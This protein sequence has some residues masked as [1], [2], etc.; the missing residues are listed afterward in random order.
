MFETAGTAMDNGMMVQADHSDS[1]SQSLSQQFSLSLN[2]EYHAIKLT[3]FPQTN[4]S[5]T[6]FGAFKCCSKV[7]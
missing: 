2:R 1:T 3:V 6:K 4:Y 7:P 5:F